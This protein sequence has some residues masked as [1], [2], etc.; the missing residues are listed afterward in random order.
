MNERMESPEERV[1]RVDEALENR[2]GRVQEGIEWT[3]KRV[4][5]VE[6]ETR[7]SSM[8]IQSEPESRFNNCD[9]LRPNRFSEIYRENAF[10]RSQGRRSQ[11]DSH[12]PKFHVFKTHIIPAEFPVEIF[13]SFPNK[14]SDSL[15]LLM[16]WRGRVISMFQKLGKLGEKCV[17]RGTSA[18]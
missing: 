14:K 9:L 13:H 10:R 8:K 2:I 1:G 4:A 17:F 12:R 11:W 15:A 5:G 18:R 16:A 3:E 6:D 7:K